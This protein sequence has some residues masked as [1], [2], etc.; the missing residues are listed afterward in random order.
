MMALV[1]I[2][3]AEAWVY[4]LR[5]RS[6][7]QR[8]WLRSAAHG[9]AVAALRVVWLSIGVSSMLEAAPLWQLVV[10]YAGSA[11]L[12]TGALHWWLERRPNLV[13]A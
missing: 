9:T 6:A 12:T 4:L 10:A 2:A 1:I 7:S 3:A 5:Y 8:C 13:E 11:G